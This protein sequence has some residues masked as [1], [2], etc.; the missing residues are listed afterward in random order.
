[1]KAKLVKGPALG[2][3]CLLQ[4]EQGSVMG[5]DKQISQ[6]KHNVEGEIRGKQEVRVTLA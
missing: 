4:K 3:K 2:P 6:P 1:M 5:A